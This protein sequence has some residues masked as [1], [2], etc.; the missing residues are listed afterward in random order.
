MKINK[1]F[2]DHCGAELMSIDYADLTI[3]IGSNYISN[4]LIDADLC[5]NCIDKLFS[6]VTEFCSVHSEQSEE[7]NND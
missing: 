5:E 1:I 6:I 3:E 7:V 4:R 2:C